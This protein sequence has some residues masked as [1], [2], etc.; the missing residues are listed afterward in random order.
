[1]TAKQPANVA[2]LGLGIMGTAIATNLEQDGLLAATWNRSNKPGFPKFRDS[3]SD[4]VRD[5]EII[6]ILVTDDRA[7]FEVL[8]LIHT[9]QRN[10]LSFSA[11]RST[12]RVILTCSYG[13]KRPV[14]VSSRH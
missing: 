8:D 7:V 4:A 2:V 1:M 3:I 11:A 9:C 5:S 12:R 14:P 13:R 6:L 10:I